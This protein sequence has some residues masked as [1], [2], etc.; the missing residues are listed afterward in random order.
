MAVE[1]VATRADG[2]AADDVRAAPSARS[3]APT[4]TPTPTHGGWPRRP[5]AATAGGRDGSPFSS[6]RK[7]SGGDVR[8]AR[9]VAVGAPE[10][11]LADGD[12]ARRQAERARRAPGLR[13]LLLART[14]APLDGRTR[15]PTGAPAALVALDQRLRADAPETLR[16]FADAGRRREGDLRRQ[17]GHG[18]GDRRAQVGVPGAGRRDRR[19]HPAATIRRSWPTWS[20]SHT[21]FGRVTPQQKREM[22]ARCSC[23]ARRVAMTGDGVNDALALKDADLGVAMGS[24]SAGHPGGREDRA[25]RR[26]FT[27]MPRVVAEG[28]RVLANIER[29]ANLFLTKTVYAM[30]LA[31]LVGVLRCRSRSCPA[32]SRW[33]AR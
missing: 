3:A 19:P 17:P 7:W 21:V 5:G 22:V 9:R 14:D 18:R 25:A 13:V 29:V 6:A 27:A 15:G 4:R 26:R 24:G 23:A 31:L 33:S 32:T 20:P 30:I 11:L 16:Y 8:R 10:V 12:P 2:A 28:R 1:D